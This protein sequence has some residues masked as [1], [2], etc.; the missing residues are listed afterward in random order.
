MGDGDAWHLPEPIAQHARHLVHVA[1]ACVAVNQAHIDAG[2]H[3]ALRVAGVDG[4]QRV[5]HL[6]ELA[7]DGFNL[8]GLGFGGFQ[9]GAHRR[10]KVERGFRKIGFGDKLGS[11]QRHHDNAERKNHNGQRQRR[12]L[13]NQRPAQNALVGIA[14]VFGGA[15]KQTRDA[16]NGLVVKRDR[17]EVLAMR[18]NRRVVPDAGKHRIQREADKHRDQHGRHNGDAELVKKLA[19]D[20]AHETNRQEHRNDGKSGRQHRQANLLCAIHRSEV[21]CFAHLH[22]AHDVFAHHDRIVDQ[23]PDTERQRH[24]RDHVDGEAE[25]VHEEEGAD[26]GNR[27]RQPGN[28]GGAPRV[29]KQEHDQHR[30]HRAF[31]QRFANICDRHANRARGIGD[32]FKPHPRRQ[33]RLHLGNGFA[34]PVHHA[35]GIFILRLLHRQQQGA[36]AVV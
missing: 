25:Q 30:Q 8:P 32:Q 5:F 29:E 36:L 16:A 17:R 2:V 23:Q 7:H 3:L 10:V 9:R 14:Q 28:H 1:R 4:G 21:A 12:Q 24:Q 20:A 19:D 34:Q 33:Q 11:Q 31:N 35:D 27:Q 22:M 15:G 26:D 18:L 13:V 6:G